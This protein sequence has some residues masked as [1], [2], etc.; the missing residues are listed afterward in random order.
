[1]ERN[2]EVLYPNGKREIMP[3]SRAFALWKAG[4]ASIIRVIA[5]DETPDQSFY[6]SRDVQSPVQ[7][8]RK[9]HDEFS[10]IDP[11]NVRREE[12]PIDY[13]HEAL[14]LNA[15]DDETDAIKEYRRLIAETARESEE[16]NIYYAIQQDE[17]RHHMTL[18]N[19]YYAKYGRMPVE[20]G[21]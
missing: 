13:K 8:L 14:I 19:M 7:S 20:K 1:M 6:V 15:I 18:R 4:K 5:I 12:A 16:W 3:Y 21:R 9:M 2:A 11:K 17:M 10:Q